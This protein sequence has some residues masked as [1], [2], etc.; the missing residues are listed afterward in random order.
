[1]SGSVSSTS[2]ALVS[3]S[4]R[5]NPSPLSSQIISSQSITVSLPENMDDLLEKV[6]ILF[7]REIEK[8]YLNLPWPKNMKNILIETT[9]SGGKGD[10]AAAAKAISL[11][12]RFCPK[13]VSIDWVHASISG[14]DPLSFLTHQEKSRV[15]HREL[16]SLPV[17]KDPADFVIIGPIVGIGKAK[18]EEYTGRKI[19]GPIYGFNEIA[20][21]HGDPT[22]IN[23]KS[24]FSIFP[25]TLRYFSMG[26]TPGSGIFLD[27]T[28]IKAPLTRTCCCPSY[29]LSIQDASLRKDI[30]ESMQVYDDRTKP[31][32][33][34]YSF[35]SG[36]AH[37][38]NL[39]GRFIEAVAIHECSKDAIIVLND[40]GAFGALS[41][42]EFFDYIFTSKRLDLLQ[43]KGYGS[44]TLKTK[45]KEISF[46]LSEDGQNM[47]NVTVITRPS[48]T[49]HD[50][51][52]LQL[53]SER[54][55]ATGDNTAIEAWCAK[56]K[57]FLYECLPHKL[58]FKEQ[59]IDLAK[60]MAPAMSRLLELPNDCSTSKLEKA[61]HDPDLEKDTLNF[62][63]Y[64][65]EHCSFGPIFEAGIKRAAWHHIIPDLVTIEEQ[66]IDKE[67]QTDLIQ[68][69]KDPKSKKFLTIN[70]LPQLEKRIQETVADYLKTEPRKD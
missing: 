66:T 51:K 29:L 18:I 67:F 30:L 1:M 56:C 52:Q 33:D 38:P 39:R 24:Y 10:I 23:F 16:R 50:M 28:R 69:V 5:I 4:A 11:V 49:P 26:I 59:Q 35:N 58:G 65:V 13:S 27:Q 60:K 31:D 34:R 19:E 62:C 9:V 6:L 12:L 2:I 57:L 64:V 45:N 42:E 32:F 70:T 8:I 61:V 20:M 14:C 54:M 36:Y 37:N 46:L 43:K 68:Y 3:A 40:R 7:Q 17:N 63:K 47:R 53:S 21:G 48:F 55:I 22:W 15:T 41:S 44:I 25:S